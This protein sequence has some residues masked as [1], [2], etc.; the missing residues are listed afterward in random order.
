MATDTDALLKVYE[1]HWA[2]ARQHENQRATITNVVL[3]IASAILGLISQQSLNIE[4]LPLAGLLIVVGI[5]GAISS[6]KL[7]ERAEYDF[8]RIRYLHGHLDKLFPKARLKKLRE[9][10]DTQH[11]SKFPRLVR[12]HVHHLWLMM[13]LAVIIAGILLIIA[14]IL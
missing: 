8:E 2:Q 9:D 10:A 11:K 14:I 3:L 13:H 4:M 12:L 1:E 6:E 7:Y 5:F